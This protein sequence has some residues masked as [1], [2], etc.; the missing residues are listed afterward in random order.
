MKKSILLTILASI[1]IL[2][3]E[4][5]LYPDGYR[6]WTHLKSSI[7]KEHKINTFIGI[8]HIYANDIAIKGLKTYRYKKGATFVLDH[9][10]MNIS[11]DS[12]KEGKRL[13]TG[14][15]VYDPIKYSKTANWGFESFIG[16]SKTKRGVK[17]SILE[18]F[19]CHTQVKKKNY[20]FSSFRE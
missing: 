13:F 10:D 7:T 12:I 9:L 4:K 5:V 16:S 11:K 14:V 17:D 18:C 6:S 20:V 1:C 15:M 3:D 19:T 2:A 8:S